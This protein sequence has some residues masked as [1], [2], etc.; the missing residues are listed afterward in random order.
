M[1]GWNSAGET[2]NLRKYLD[3]W[4]IRAIATIPVG[5]RPW[6]MSLSKSGDRLYVANGRSHSVTVIDTVARKALKDVAV[7]QAP[8]G[9]AAY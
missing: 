9:T 4:A 8:W 7:G 1:G 6:N 5:E 2:S 3:D